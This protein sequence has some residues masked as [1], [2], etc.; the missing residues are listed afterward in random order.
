ML[1]RVRI[2]VLCGECRIRTHGGNYPTTVFKTAALNHSANSPLTT[3]SGT[4]RI[5]K[6]LLL[7][8]YTAYMRALGIDYGSKRIGLAVSDD[9]GMLAFPHS[10]VN[11]TSRALASI[12]GICE[13]EQITHIAIGKS[14]N[15]SGAENI[16]AAAASEFAKLLEEATNIPVAFI[17]EGFSSF[18]AARSSRI[19][20]PVANPRRR[21]HSNDAHDDQAAAII[22]QRYLDTQKK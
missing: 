12:A 19:E 18:E 17:N 5:F 2:H 13:K 15:A 21:E 6:Y 20:K 7:A 1:F 4:S 8:W 3:I 16:I 22:L 10:I 14:V 11:N 9:A